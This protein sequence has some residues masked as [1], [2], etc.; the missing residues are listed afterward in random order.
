MNSQSKSIYHIM[1]LQ[2]PDR[3]G[4]EEVSTLEEAVRLLRNYQQT[5]EQ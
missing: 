5:L 1:S 2:L 3:P 4:Q